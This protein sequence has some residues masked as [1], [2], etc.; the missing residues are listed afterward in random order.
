MTPHPTNP[1]HCG[2]L[3]SRIAGFNNHQAAMADGWLARHSEDQIIC[4]RIILVIPSRATA[5]Y[6]KACRPS[7][8][9]IFLSVTLE[10]L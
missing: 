3:R 9:S 6:G 1:P 2:Q 4:R 10:L 7:V 5:S 8:V